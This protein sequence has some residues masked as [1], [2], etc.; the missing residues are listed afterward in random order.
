MPGVDSH[1][2]RRDRVRLNRLID[3]SKNDGVARDV[4][5]D[6]S[7]CEVRDDFLFAVL[8]PNGKGREEET[9]HQA[10]KPQPS[11]PLACPSSKSARHEYFNLTSLSRD[12]HGESDS[13]DR[14]STRLNSSHGSISY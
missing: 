6:T 13:R 7:A 14:K 3:G 12:F 10:H 1:D 5:N 2:A 8:R 4:H 11:V 9:N